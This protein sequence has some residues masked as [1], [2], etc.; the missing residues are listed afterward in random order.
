[1]KFAVLISGNGTNLQAIID[2][3]RANQIT[4]ELALVVSDREDAFG[5][6]RAE[7]AGIKT[8]IFKPSNY[9][10]PQSVD[11]DMVSCL[12]QGGID[13]VVLA[14]YMR[15]LTPFFIK[16]FPRKVIN[17]HPALLPSFKG[18]QGIKDAV[19][20]GVKVTGVTIHFVDEKMDHGPIIMQEAV[21]IAEEDSLES[22]EE[23]IHALEH[24]LYPQ[25]IQLLVED[26]LQIKG[27]RVEI[28]SK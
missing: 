3:V 12:K 16:E 13:F 17:I 19:S 7:K 20:Y 25:A 8:M 4:A 22:L 6:Q 26:R 21:P 10:N 9:T 23:K 24:R 11:R 18:I 5:L 15:I 1:M 2:A 28:V 14:G 27:R